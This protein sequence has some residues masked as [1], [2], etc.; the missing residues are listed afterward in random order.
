[1][2]QREKNRGGGSDVAVIQARC[3]GV[4]D[5]AGAF[6]VLAAA[7]AD[8]DVAEGA[9]VG[10]VPAAG[11]AEVAG[12]GEVVVVVVAE[13]CVGGVAAW[14]S[15]VLWLRRWPARVLWLCGSLVINRMI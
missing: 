14:T 12:L 11:F 3:H 9:T 8:G 4:D 6:G 15:K 5:R 1:M 2:I 13:L 7:T 10:P